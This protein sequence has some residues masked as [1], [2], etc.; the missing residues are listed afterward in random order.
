MGN[1]K[2]ADVINNTKGTWEWIDNG[3]GTNGGATVYDADGNGLLRIT[4]GGMGISQDGGLTYTNAITRDGVLASRLSVQQNGV[5]LLDA[6]SESDTEV[7]LSMYHPSSEQKVFDVQAYKQ[8]Y[9]NVEWSGL[10]LYDPNS[11]IRWLSATATHAPGYHTNARFTI[12]NIDS[13]EVAYMDM[14]TLVKSNNTN[15]AE[16][17]MYNGSTREIIGIGYEDTTPFLRWWD[18]STTRQLTMQTITQGGLTYHLLG[19]VS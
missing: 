4:A 19:Y 7:H 1:Q 13:E 8:S 5:V 3:D 10:Q 2:A 14:Q 15:A 17:S 6:D 18:G 9:N 11:G 12:T 16:L